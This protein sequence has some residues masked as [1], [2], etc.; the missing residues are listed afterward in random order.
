MSASGRLGGPITHTFD[1]DETPPPMPSSWR[2]LGSGEPMNERK[3]G[4]HSL[5]LAGRSRA[6]ST[7]AFD[8]PPRMKTAG[9]FRC[10]MARLVF[11]VAGWTVNQFEG[12]D[13]GRRDGSRGRVASSRP[14][15][16]PG[17]SV[18]AAMQAQTCSIMG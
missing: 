12:Y 2:M 3:I 17:G 1:S 7:T 10:D 14:H 6:W 15:G 9:S 4:A 18:D 11:V 13:D 5:R 8:V 16:A